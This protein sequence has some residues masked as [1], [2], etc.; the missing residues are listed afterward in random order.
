MSCLL[1]MRAAREQMST[2]EK[3]LADFI[4]ANSALIR[5][6]SSQQLASSV[7]VSQSSVVKF[8]QKLG[9]KGFTDLKLAIHETVVRQDSGGAEEH[10]LAHGSHPVQTIP[11]RVLH[12]KCEVLA[13]TGLLNDDECLLAAVKA[14][15]SGKRFQIAAVGAA[16]LVAKD[17]ASKLLVLGYPVSAEPEAYIQLS[18]VA[19]LG[20]GDVLFVI[21]AA[22]QTRSLIHMAQQARKAGALIVTLTAYNSNPL[23][24]L[25]D[26][27]LYSASHNGQPN[28]PQILEPV[29]QQHVIDLLFYHL[30]ERNARG[31]ELLI[32]DQKA[33]A[34]LA[35]RD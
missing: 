28:I 24:A 4:L 23:N 9:Y 17:F 15:E 16:T 21:C 7:G 18:G 25:A 26:I 10:E 22:G 1:K 35:K 6:Y 30:V 20:R 27:R 11:Q 31:R 32:R 14:I 29:S 8:S 34:D 12:S 2:S 5:D 19:T 13:S 3:K 33:Q